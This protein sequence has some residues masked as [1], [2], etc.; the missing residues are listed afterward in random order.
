[1]S[2]KRNNCIICRK[3]LQGHHLNTCSKK[4]KLACERVYTSIHYINNKGS[5][6][7][8]M[9][10]NYKENRKERLKYQQIK[11]WNNQKTISYD[12]PKKNMVRDKVIEYVNT[13][14][15]KNILTL[16][17][18]DYLFSKE[19]IDKKIYVYEHLEKIYKSMKRNKPNNVSLFYGDV[20]EFAELEIDVDCIYLDFCSTL[21]T[22]METLKKL[23]KVL[24]RSKLFAITIC[25]FNDEQGEGDYQM[26]IL[27]RIIEVTGINWKP[28]ISY[29]YKD[30]G[31]MAM[32]TL[33]LENQ[34]IKEVKLNGK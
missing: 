19:L 16:E 5:Y 18:P 34:T 15:I 33:I 23:K 25:P 21:K 11:R 10:N 24:E 32:F 7:N 28:L 6:Q 3:K 14:N 27:R 1:M 9:K 13:F 8:F 20:S 2:R 30:E 31:K 22:N 4:C 17:S 12:R 26:R 29:G